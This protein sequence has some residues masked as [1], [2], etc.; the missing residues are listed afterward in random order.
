MSSRVHNYMLNLYHITI[1][2]ARE[3]Q[4]CA[5]RKI[6]VSENEICDRREGI[7]CLFL[8]GPAQR[9]MIICEIM[10]QMELHCGTQESKKEYMLNQ[11]K[12]CIQSISSKGRI[13]ASWTLGKPCFIH[14]E[15]ILCHLF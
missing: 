4:V 5:M 2:A 3:R 8:V 13:S 14:M 7:P 10:R 15:H 6:A 1:I 9:S 12:S 11:T